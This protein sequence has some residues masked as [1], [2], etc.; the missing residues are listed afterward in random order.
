MCDAGW[1]YC[2]ACGWDLT[3][4]VGDA[5]EERLQSV[6]RASVGVTVLGRRNRYATAFPF[7]GADLLL[8]NA[9]VLVGADASSVRLRTYNNRD[10]S[11]SIVGYDLPSGVGVLKA[12]IPGA[13]RPEVALSPP[14]TLESSWSVCYPIVLE[15]DVVRYLPVS[16]HRGQ[17]TATD[18]TGTALVS[19]EDL[20][21][22][23]HAIEDGCTG[24][25]LIDA[26]GRMAGMILGS[27]D[28]GIT[29]VLPLEGLQSI[30]D[31]LVRHQRPE[32][33]FFGLG[34]VSP[35]ERRRS[36]FGI[37]S[38][39]AHPLVAYLIPGSPALRAGV[40]PGD[41]LLAV[42]DEKVASVLEAGRRLLATG[43]G[44]DGITLTLQRGTVEVRVTVRSV[45]RPDRV[46]L[47]PIDE[48]QETLEANLKEIAS[49]PSAQQGLHVSDLV[50]GGRGEKGHFRNGDIIVSVEKK[51]VRTF[52]SL[53]DVIR[54][55]FKEI[56]S[57]DGPADR[58]YASSYVVDLEIRAE[59]QDKV[60]REYVNLFP[61]FL[62]PPVF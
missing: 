36:K 21:R 35:D 34:L 61:D 45:K 6:A 54:T 56:F 49:G 16:L 3:T 57:E 18:Q 32:R 41:V 27:P 28:A 52:Q 48:L 20:L 26:R 31:A 23:D 47:D 46:L 10:Y 9:R 60:T 14:A 50:R 5:E 17:V 55:K 33:P 42:G 51:S 1:H 30:V 4:L 24:G 13:P 11:A 12:E 7:G 58:Q 25:P 38:Q 53:D 44:G 40:L 19:F 43:T 8:T 2:A 62:A 59:G 15:D 22:T 37:Q 29:Y 39:P